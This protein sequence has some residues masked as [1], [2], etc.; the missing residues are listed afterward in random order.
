MPR[1]GP[2]RS[3]VIALVMLAS[4]GATA[5][6]APVEHVSSP[7]SNVSYTIQFPSTAAAVAIENMSVQVF[8]ASAPDFCATLV[9]KRRSSA[10]LP[11]PLAEL[12]S[13]TPC[14][15]LSGTGTALTVPNGTVAILVVAKR[16]GEELLLG[17][18]LQEVGA[19]ASAATVSLTLFDGTK[20]IPPTTCTHLSEKCAGRC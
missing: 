3:A 8:A 1:R 18:A 2:D 11:A 12:T 4:A 19:G 7:P 6:S 20:S 16:G 15:A 10:E 5:C 17:C 9:A 14:A 13:I